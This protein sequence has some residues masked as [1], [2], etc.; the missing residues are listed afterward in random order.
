M[1]QIEHDYFVQGQTDCRA[2]YTS[3]TY[4]GFQ[5]PMAPEIAMKLYWPNTEETHMMVSAPLPKPRQKWIAGFRKEQ[6]I[7]LAEQVVTC[8]RCGTSLGD[9]NE[10]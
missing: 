2:F 6:I 7:I 3:P 10:K 9:A 8:K 1:S 5:K 4:A